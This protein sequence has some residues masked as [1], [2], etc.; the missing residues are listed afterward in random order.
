MKQMRRRQAPA[1][2][3]ALLLALTSGDSRLNT[4]ETTPPS[5]P[6]NPATGPTGTFGPDRWLEKVGKRVD[7]SKKDEHYEIFSR[8][9]SYDCIFSGNGNSPC[10][11][12]TRG[13]RKT[14]ATS[15]RRSQ[16][17]HAK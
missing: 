9:N 12:P 13:R 6:T 5:I 11:S 2:S 15:G 14:S 8:D 10:A 4:P 7:G 3:P 17:Q 16:E 1:A